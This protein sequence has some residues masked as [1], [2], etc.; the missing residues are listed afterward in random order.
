[1]NFTSKIIAGILIPL[2]F[3]GGYWFFIRNR[4]PFLD[5][6]KTD[7]LNNIAI[8]K[9]GNNT[10]FV[11]L[12]NNGQMNAGSTYSDKYKLEFTSNN[13]LMIFIVKEKNGNIVNKQTL[14]FGAKIKY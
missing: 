5:L 1:M 8:I 10:K 13:K 11:S 6:E 12:G 4:E 14:D 2:A 7:W 9:F 3:F